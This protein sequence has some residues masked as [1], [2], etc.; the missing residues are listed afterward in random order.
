MSLLI[1]NGAVITIEGEAV[2]DAW[3]G[4][5][6]SNGDVVGSVYWTNVNSIAVFVKKVILLVWR[7]E[8]H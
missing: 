8:K 7:L 6:N 1:Q 2:T 3:I 4:V 5:T